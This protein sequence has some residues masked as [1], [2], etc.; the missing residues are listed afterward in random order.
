M[1][2]LLPERDTD[3]VLGA[4]ASW[5]RKLATVGLAVF[6]GAWLAP[7]PNDQ[8]LLHD[9]APNLLRA[10]ADGAIF[11]LALI[12]LVGIVVFVLRRPWGGFATWMAAA[13]GTASIAA[14][15]VLIA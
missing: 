6:T 1:F 14:S 10:L 9:G 5:H 2:I 12:A 7:S 15:L 4:T 11:T 3:R 13:S 8:G